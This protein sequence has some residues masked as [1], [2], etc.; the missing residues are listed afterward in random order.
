D[1][2][3]KP[4]RSAFDVVFDGMDV[5]A[6]DAH[7]LNGNSGIRRRHF[8]SPRGAADGDDRG[9]HSGK[10]EWRQHQNPPFGVVLLPDRRTTRG[11]VGIPTFPC[12]ILRLS[13]KFWADITT[14]SSREFAQISEIPRISRLSVSSV[15]LSGSD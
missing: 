4:W 3:L 13:S 1:Q 9:Q 6:I 5:C 7:L 12:C 2:G 11:M 10:A 14:R 15:S 8:L